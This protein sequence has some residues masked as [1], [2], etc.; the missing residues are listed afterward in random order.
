MASPMSSRGGTV[1]ALP[2]EEVLTILR[3]RR[4]I[5]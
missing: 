2:I 5:R 3:D 4:A 1:E